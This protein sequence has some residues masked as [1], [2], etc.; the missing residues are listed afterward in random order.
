MAGQHSI[1]MPDSYFEV[2]YIDKPE[3]PDLP[4]TKSGVHDEEVD[5]MDL[6]RN[7]DKWSKID[8]K[9]GKVTLEQ[10]ESILTFASKQYGKALCKTVFP[11]LVDVR[12]LDEDKAEQGVSGA[13][14]IV[15]VLYNYDPNVLRKFLD[16]DGVQEFTYVWHT[17]DTSDEE[18]FQLPFMI[19]R[20]GRGVKESPLPQEPFSSR[21]TGS[22]VATRSDSRTKRLQAI[23]IPSSALGSSPME[24]G[25]WNLQEDSTTLV[26]TIS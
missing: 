20:K 9:D 22:S 3:F 14:G 19:T 15:T 18:P 17:Q 11:R 24:S 10:F 4:S 12:D 16:V 6:E 21:L 25:K 5:D 2:K 23:G 1:C 7:F 8:N 13:D 26:W